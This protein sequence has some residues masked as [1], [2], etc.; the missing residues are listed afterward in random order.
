MSITTSF[1]NGAYHIS[2]N[3]TEYNPQ[4]KNNFTL[5]IQGI[6][7]LPR[8]DS[9]DTDVNNLPDS[10]IVAG[11][12]EQIALALKSSDVPNFSQSEI[13]INRGNSTIKFAGKPSFN[14]LN[15]EVYDFIGSNAKDVLYAWQYQQYNSRYDFVGGARSYKKNCQLL[16]LTPDGDLVRYWEIKGA[17]LKSV[18]V[19]S[20]S[21]TDDDIQ[22]ISAELVYDWATMKMPSEYRV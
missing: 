11:G 20:F 7:T 17:W 13:S 3:A 21:Y 18:S 12:Q 4:R 2:N 16:Q 1:S 22:T 15:I 8:V 5:I 10:S 19:G 6:D 9:V 14:T